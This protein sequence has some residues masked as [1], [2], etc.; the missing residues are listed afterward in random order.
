MMRLYFID[1]IWK[2]ASLFDYF[3]KKGRQIVTLKPFILN[4]NRRD[5]FS[6]YALVA[7]SICI[8]SNE[9]RNSF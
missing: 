3:K 2:I 9:L 4:F 8:N 1:E 5:D 6:F 7:N